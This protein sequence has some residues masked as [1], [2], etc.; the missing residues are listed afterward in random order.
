VR[1]AAAKGQKPTISGLEAPGALRRRRTL[2]TPMK[3]GI[4][5]TIRLPHLLQAKSSGVIGV[6]RG[7]PL[8]PGSELGAENSWMLGRRAQPCSLMR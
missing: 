5:G 2:R 8:A 6:Y 7:W 4:Y 3:R 1:T